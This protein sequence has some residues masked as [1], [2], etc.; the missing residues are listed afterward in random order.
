MTLAG[1]FALV[2]GGSRGIGRGIALKLAESGAKVA[3]HYYQKED[4]AK[5]T[6][7]KIRSLGADG[8][9]VQADVCKPDEIRRMFARVK[10][11]FGALDIF[12]NNARPEVPTFYQGPMDISLEMFD[13]AMDSQAKAFL[14][15]VREAAAL[16]RDGGR[17]IGI[18]YAPGGRFGS[19]QPWVAMGAAKAALEVLCRYFAVALAPR[20]ITVNA[21]SPGWTD[22]SVLNTLPEAAQKMISNWQAAGWT[23]MRRLGLPRDIGNA[24]AL[25]CSAEANWITG[26]LL[27]VDGGASLMNSHAPLEIQQIPAAKAAHAS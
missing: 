2:T 12:V 6:L 13:F 17:V 11:E 18:T 23:P 26:Q 19:W 16:M 7:A 10:S 8:F 21:V 25:L 22:D 5:N 24:V 1:K 9:V 4:Q 20:Q 14:V 15:G 27:E 3:V